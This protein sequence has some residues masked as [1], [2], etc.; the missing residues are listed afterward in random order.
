M[1]QNKADLIGNV[2]GE[3]TILEII[4]FYRNT[5]QKDYK[6]KV[7]CNHCKG[8]GILLLR[9]VLNGKSKGCGCLK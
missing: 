9:G 3:L 5:N 2:F 8:N 4:P 7:F 6:C 1:K